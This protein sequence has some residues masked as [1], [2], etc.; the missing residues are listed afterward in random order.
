M[1]KC[2]RVVK[3][4]PNET[5][6]PERPVASRRL[7]FANV[8]KWLGISLSWNRVSSPHAK[9]FVCFRLKATTTE[10]MLWNNARFAETNTTRTWKLSSMASLI[11]LIVSSVPFTPWLRPANI[12]PAKLS[13]MVSNPAARFIAVPIVPRPKEWSEPTTTFNARR[14]LADNHRIDPLRGRVAAVFGLGTL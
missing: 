5:K 7:I 3:K 13:A 9:H 4:L 11:I 14:W 8:L 6:A 12:A 10:V 2:S 1:T